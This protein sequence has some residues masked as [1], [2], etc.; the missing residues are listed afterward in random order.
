MLLFEGDLMSAIVWGN[1]LPQCVRRLRI[2]NAIILP[3]LESIG[4][5]M[6]RSKVISI[7]AVLPFHLLSECSMNSSKTSLIILL[8][9]RPLAATVDPM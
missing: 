9:G 2:S 6:M 1:G 4:R 3:Q 7:F 5:D 8:L